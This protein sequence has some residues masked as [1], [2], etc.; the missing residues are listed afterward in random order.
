MSDLAT[1]PADTLR[2]WQ[3]GA[4][5]ANLTDELSAYSLELRRRGEPSHAFFGRA[6]TPARYL[7]KGCGAESPAGIGYAVSVPSAL[8][9]PAP[10][11]PHPHA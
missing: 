2:T 11:C 7:C 5:Y 8:P 10:D 4:W 9:A 6:E 3:A 1:I